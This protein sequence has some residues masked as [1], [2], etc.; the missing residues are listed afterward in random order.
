MSTSQQPKRGKTDE[1]LDDPTNIVVGVKAS[2]EIQKTA[3]VWALKHV[4][5]PGD[6]I[7]LIVVVSP[8]NSGNILLSTFDLLW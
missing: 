1:A 5:Q 4:V 6:C 8:H 3:L 7:T 2:K